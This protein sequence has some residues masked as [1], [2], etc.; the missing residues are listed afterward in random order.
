MPQSKTISFVT[1]PD[2]RVDEQSITV[3]GERIARERF[4][5][6]WLPTEFFGAAP[7]GYAADGIWRG[8]AEKG[9][10]VHTIEIA[11]DGTPSLANK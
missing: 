11:K 2:G 5:A 9:F 8:A 7:T 10:R 6:T 1:Y 3:A 4:I